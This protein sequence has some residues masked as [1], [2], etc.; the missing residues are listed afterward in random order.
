M[1]ICGS[2]FIESWEKSQM[3]KQSRL[4]SRACRGMIAI[5]R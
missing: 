5:V 1:E 4:E 3:K 2:I